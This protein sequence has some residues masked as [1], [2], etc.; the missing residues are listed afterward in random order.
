MNRFI[1]KLTVFWQIKM[2]DINSNKPG[3]KQLGEL[4]TVLKPRKLYQS[5]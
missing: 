2:K 5:K 3:R 4:F 1:A